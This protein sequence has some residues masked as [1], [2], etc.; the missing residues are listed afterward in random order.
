[1]GL[2]ERIGYNI[3]EYL[4]HSIRYVIRHDQ[5]TEP[6]NTEAIIKSAEGSRFTSAVGHSLVYNKRDNTAYPTSGY[7]VKLSQ[8]FAGLGGSVKYIKNEVMGTRHIA[9]YK[10]DVILHLVMRA[11]NIS[12]LFNQQ[13]QLNNNFYL[14]HDYIR[15]FDLNG[16]GPRT[17]HGGRALGGKSYYT[18]RAEVRFPMGNALKDFGVT[19]ITFLDAASLFSVDISKNLQGTPQGTMCNSNNISQCAYFDSS[20]IR[21]SY[22]AG[23]IWDS[24][25]LGVIKIFYAIP[26]RKEPFDIESNFG[27]S[28]SSEF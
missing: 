16:I 2:S 11:G 25:I 3:T 17:A 6:N 7:F 19:G 22:G 27:I 8:E 15:G 12:G 4:G 26:F 23:V 18:A 5:I 21:M 13:V 9:L 20:R 10:N 24:P 1:M 14:D 28:F